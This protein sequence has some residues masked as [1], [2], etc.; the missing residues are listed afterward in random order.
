MLFPAFVLFRH[1]VLIG[2]K[3]RRKKNIEKL[4]LTIVIKNSQNVFVG[5]IVITDF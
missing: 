1:H 3:I 4:K 5:P 2:K